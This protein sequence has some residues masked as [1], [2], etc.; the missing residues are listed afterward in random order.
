MRVA[1][2]TSTF[3]SIFPQPG[4]DSGRMLELVESYRPRIERMIEMRMTPSLR[5]RVDAADILQEACVEVHRRLDAYRS[6]PD[7]SLYAFVRFLAIQAL[8]HEYR[9]HLGPAK[10]DM[11]REVQLVPAGASTL[12]LEMVSQTLVAS[13]IS[14]SESFE[15]SEESESLRKSIEL[16]DE[17]DLEIIATRYAEGLN[18][19]DAAEVLG[20][21]QSAASRRLSRALA[22][23]E[24][25]CR[26]APGRGSTPLSRE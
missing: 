14:P 9:R 22:H 17:E 5:Q 26:N 19:K 8:N 15:N 25:A 13:G 2:M 20:I 7:M 1:L 11:R 18:N 4:E 24:E 6:K 23:L 3:E 12:D 21:S 16:L 10:R